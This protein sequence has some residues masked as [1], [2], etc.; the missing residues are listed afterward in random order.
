MQH[1]FIIHDKIIQ[2]SEEWK[3]LRLGKITGSE[4]KDLNGTK[5]AREKY[6]YKKATEIMLGCPSDQDEFSKIGNNIHVQRG[7]LHE[8]IAA[9]HYLADKLKYVQ[10]VGLVE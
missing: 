7:S 8:E 6:L 2:G 9:D 3:A 1:E 4:F 10:V 5:A